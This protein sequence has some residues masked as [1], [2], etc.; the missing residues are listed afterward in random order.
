MTG[1]YARWIGGWQN[2]LATR[3][4]NR[5]RRPVGWG[6]DWLESIPFPTFPSHAN[7]NSAAC[8]GGFVDQVLADSD[9]FFACQ[10]VRDYRI[11][12][13]ELTFTSPVQTRY[14]ENNMA[15]ALWFP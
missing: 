2:S 5:V 11:A 9:R 7:G 3:D 14:P 6:V 10:P 1:P 12:N 15:R 4:A 13:G 8:V